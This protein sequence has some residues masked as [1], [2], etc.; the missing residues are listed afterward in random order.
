M[1]R[2]AQLTLSSKDL[3]FGV[4]R[5]NSDD[6][7]SFL[8][9][10]EDTDDIRDENEHSIKFFTEKDELAYA[11]KSLVSSTILSSVFIRADER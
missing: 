10:V 1:Y 2:E 5:Y 7:T 4:K 6:K 11:G 8:L 3:K 9:E